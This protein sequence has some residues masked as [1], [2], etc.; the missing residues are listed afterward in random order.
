VKVI[1]F[2]SDRPL[3]PS[4]AAAALG[5]SSARLLYLANN[6]TIKVFRT[7]GGHRRYSISAIEEYLNALEE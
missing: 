4:E 6:G 2:Y 5:I 7:P 1:H 3:R